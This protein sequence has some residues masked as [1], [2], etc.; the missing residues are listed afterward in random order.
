[1]STYWMLLNEFL[2]SVVDIVIV[3]ELK[4]QITFKVFYVF[5]LT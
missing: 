5:E 2:K 3:V 1:M 4:Q